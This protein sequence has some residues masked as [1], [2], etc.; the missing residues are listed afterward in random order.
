[1]NAGLELT[2]LE[3]AMRWRLRCVAMVVGRRCFSQ[4]GEAG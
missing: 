1:M 2:A 4:A 3:A